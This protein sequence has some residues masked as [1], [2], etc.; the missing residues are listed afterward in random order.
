MTTQDRA[1]IARL[2]P[3]QGS[4]CLLDAVTSW[5]AHQLCAQANN[6]TLEH[7]PLRNARGLPATAGIEYA[8]QAMAVHGAL[9]TGQ[10]G[11][12]VQGRLVAIRQVVCTRPWLHDIA[13][14]L[15]IE[16]QHLMSDARTMMYQF[17]V[18]AADQELVSGRATV[19]LQPEFL[20]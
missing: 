14:P 17:S 2:I 19:N 8:A 20:P 4:M 6:H 13:T 7:H 16:V 1:A 12:P 18:S 15:T 11:P 3:H 10:Q 9:R 5:D